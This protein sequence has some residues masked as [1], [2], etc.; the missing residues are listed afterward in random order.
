MKNYINVAVSQIEIDQKS[1]N[2]LAK[3]RKTRT[4]PSTLGLKNF[5]L[6]KLWVIFFFQVKNVF[7]GQKSCL[8]QKRFLGQKKNSGQKI[9]K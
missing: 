5:G 2:K 6:G 9:E 4:S 7:S 8:G 1:K 3:A